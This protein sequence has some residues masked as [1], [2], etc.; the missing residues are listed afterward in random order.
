MTEPTWLERLLEPLHQLMETHPWLYATL[1][2]VVMG[3][4]GVCLG[5]LAERLFSWL[6]I[7]TYRRPR[8]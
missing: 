7:R 4:A 6:G 8:A 2:V 5:F 1:V 3:V